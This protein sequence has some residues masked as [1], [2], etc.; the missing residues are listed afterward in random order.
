MFSKAR[1]GSL[2]NADHCLSGATRS[3]GSVLISQS[4]SSVL[5]ASSALRVRCSTTSAVSRPRALSQSNAGTQFCGICGADCQKS[6]SSLASMASVLSAAMRARNAAQRSAG[7]LD[8]A[9]P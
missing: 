4:A 9:P 7:S 5:R 1:S 2:I 3:S 6:R 8:W